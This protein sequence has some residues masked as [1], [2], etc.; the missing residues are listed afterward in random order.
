MTTRKT[1]SRR[2]N[3]PEEVVRTKAAEVG[4]ANSLVLE[5][6]DHALFV[7]EVAVHAHELICGRRTTRNTRHDTGRKQRTT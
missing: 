3:R 7:I 5:V 4:L 1:I 2:K 6:V